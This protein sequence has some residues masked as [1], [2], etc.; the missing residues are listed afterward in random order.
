MELTAGCSTLVGAVR[1]GLDHGK[2][3]FQTDGAYFIDAADGC[4]HGN[5]KS[6]ADEQGAFAEGGRVGVLLD[7]DAGWLRFYR[8]NKRCGP[9]FAEGVTGRRWCVP[10]SVQ[11]YSAGIKVAVLPGAVA[12]EGAGAA[13]EPPEETAAPEPEPE[14]DPKQII[15]RRPRQRRG[16]SDERCAARWRSRCSWSLRAA[17]G[18]AAQQ[19]FCARHCERYTRPCKGARHGSSCSRHCMI[20]E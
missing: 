18:R 11:T 8:N 14:P 20:N 6:N 15:S 13:D 4:L 16:A 3:H 19:A 2:T 17:R 9:S 5:G 1:P 7:P 12:P 10:Y